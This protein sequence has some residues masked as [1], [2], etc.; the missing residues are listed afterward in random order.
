MSDVMRPGDQIDRNVSASQ[1]PVVGQAGGTG[2][3]PTFTFRT[4]DL[5]VTGVNFGFEFRF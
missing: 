3:R 1:L 4:S 5:W 2:T